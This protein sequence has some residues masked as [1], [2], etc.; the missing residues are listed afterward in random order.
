MHACRSFGLL[1]W[2]ARVLLVATVATRVGDPVGVLCL[3]LG[4]PLV[5][6]SPSVVGGLGIQKSPQDPKE[7]E[8]PS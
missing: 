6:L 5:L 3:G 1:G 4:R 8:I 7:Q 2:L